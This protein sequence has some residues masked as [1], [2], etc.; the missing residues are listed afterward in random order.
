MQ[1]A[2]DFVTK[3]YWEKNNW[4]FFSVLTIIA[5]LVFVTYLYVSICERLSFVHVTDQL[6]GTKVIINTQRRILKANKRLVD[7]FCV[8]GYSQKSRMCDT[9]SCKARSRWSKGNP[10]NPRSILVCACTNVHVWVCHKHSS[11]P[12]QLS[13]SNLVCVRCLMKASSSADRQEN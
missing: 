8:V 7:H 5:I 11:Y 10:G 12:L 6:F 9:W 2:I 3:C 1:L 13:H 4:E